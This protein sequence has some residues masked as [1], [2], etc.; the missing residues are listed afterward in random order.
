MKI[1]INTGNEMKFQI[2]KNILSEYGIVC[3]RRKIDTPEIQA[4]TNKEIAEFSAKFAH[5]KN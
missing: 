3:E 1:I 4:E 2:A 5:E